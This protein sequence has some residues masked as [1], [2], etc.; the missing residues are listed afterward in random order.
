M[1]TQHTPDMADQVAVY[2]LGAVDA[3]TGECAE[4]R[5]HLAD[6]AICQEEYRQA[7][8][9]A[10]ALGRSAAQAPPNSL[11]D[12]IV[13]SLP[14]RV[15]PLRRARYSWF[16]PTA[17]AAVVVI[18]VGIFWKTHAVAPQTWAVNCTP[19]AQPC[20]VLGSLATSRQGLELRLQGLAALPAGKQY[21]T[22]LILPK[23]A[24]KPEPVFSPDARGNGDVLIPEAPSK[25][26]IVAVTVE[27]AGGS[28]KPTT[29][30]ILAATIE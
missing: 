10:A 30:P 27:P 21:Q 15:I 3:T 9:A 20:R 17:A 4:I 18:A 14:A 12:R 24:P 8:A 6:C 25:G 23:T 29:K 13:G 1:S 5:A 28:L 22:W 7:A 19:A 26:A 2:A 11:K 16:L